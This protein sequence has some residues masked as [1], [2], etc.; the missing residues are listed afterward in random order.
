MLKIA[1]KYDMIVKK[2]VQYGKV[3]MQII[4]VEIWSNR[5]N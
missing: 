3:D 5:W 1:E 4:V 2:E